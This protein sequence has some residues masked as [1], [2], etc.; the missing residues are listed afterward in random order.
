MSSEPQI[1]TLRRGETSDLP[2]LEEMLYEA[3]HWHPERER[4]DQR[5]F[6]EDESTRKYLDHWGRP[7]DGAVIALV[8]DRPVG[9]GWFRLWTNDSE[10]YGFVDIETP[11]LGLAVVA[12]HRSRGIGR[13]L[14]RRL[15]DE[16]RSLGF[17]RIS[18]S[19]E[20]ENFAIRLY[21]SEGFRRVG[22]SGTSWTL[23]KDLD[24][25]RQAPVAINL[26]EKLALLSEHWSP[27]VVA[28]LNDYQFKLVKIEGEFVWHTH[29]E[30]DEAFLVI[31]GEMEIG[32]RDRPDV[33]VRA[34]ELFVIPKGAEHITRAE[35]E[36]AA[37]II[38]PRG[39]VNTGETGGDL[40]ARNDVW[41]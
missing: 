39:V 10:S 6:F 22:E 8:G 19:V 29:D 37:L 25:V 20:P 27:R 13:E 36:C 12:E 31:K 28:E 3:F 41:L 9:A 34:G 21:E 26:E 30:T 16:A 24:G 7:G 17:S 18:L 2:F 4:P 40:T 32:F 33:K 14:L 35:D 15:M 23:L 38:E 11:E 5:V 1:V